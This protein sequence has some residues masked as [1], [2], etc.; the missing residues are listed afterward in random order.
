MP[1]P[2]EGF[3]SSQ[4]FRF[5]RLKSESGRVPERFRVNGLGCC[6]PRTRTGEEVAGWSLGRRTRPRGAM[7]VLGQDLADRAVIG[8]QLVLRV[9]HLLG[10]RLDAFLVWVSGRVASASGEA[11]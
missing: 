3:V 5:E 8:V 4:Q 1:T 10:T 6:G 2:V 7:S 9:H 11:A